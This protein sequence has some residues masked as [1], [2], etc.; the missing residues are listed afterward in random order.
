MN[1]HA[2]GE[3]ALFIDF[4]NIR[5]SMVKLYGQEPDPQKLMAKALKYG[6]VSV[7]SA[8]ADF[9]RHPEALARRFEVA[10]IARVDVPPK[11]R[12]DHEESRVDL[13]MLLDIIDALLD[14][15]QVDIFVLMTG[16]SDFIRVAVKLKNRFGKKVIISGVP[17]AVSNDLVQ[18]ASGSDP[19]EVDEGLS[20]EVLRKELIRTAAYLEIK[21]KQPT[22]RGIKQW[23]SDPRCKL[24]ISADK[25]HRLLDEMVQAGLFTRNVETAWVNEEPREITVTRLNREHPEVAGVLVST[26]SATPPPAPVVAA[27]TS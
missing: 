10:G 6:R 7:A 25:A 4:E 3:V 13:F 2:G 16:D 1:D 27:E 15:P 22:F 21:W 20:D 24:G 26:P 17:G 23:V 5:Y 9:S 12:T 8:Y 18:C 14:R 19:V 11:V